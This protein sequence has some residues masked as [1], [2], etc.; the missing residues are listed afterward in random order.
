MHCSVFTARSPI[1]ILSN[2]LLFFL[3]NK[4]Q[5]A[6]ILRSSEL[7]FFWRDGCVVEFDQ[8]RNG[9]YYERPI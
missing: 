5:I 7:A 2:L 4:L 3:N 9:I 6:V 8:T 1:P